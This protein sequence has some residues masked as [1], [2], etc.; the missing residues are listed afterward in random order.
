MREEKGRG[1]RDGAGEGEVDEKRKRDGA[2]K[3]GS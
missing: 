3:R 1:G 2:A